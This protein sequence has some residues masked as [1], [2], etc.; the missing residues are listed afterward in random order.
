MKYIIIGVETLNCIFNSNGI[1]ELQ[2]SK[3]AIKNND[4]M[5]FV[6]QHLNKRNITATMRNKID[7]Y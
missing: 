4:S 7:I 2:F 6:A 5:A 1:L 3:I